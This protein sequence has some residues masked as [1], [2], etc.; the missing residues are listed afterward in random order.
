LKNEL[1]LEGENNKLLELIIKE[2]SRLNTILTE[3]LQYAKLGET[4]LGKVDLGRIV[5]EVIE[6]AKKHPSYQARIDLR[7][8]LGDF[9]LYILAEENQLKQLLLNLLVNALEAMEEKG[10]ELIITCMPSDLEIVRNYR[11]EKLNEDLFLPLAIIDQGKGIPEE[12]MSKIFLPFYSTKKNGTG[13]GLAIVQR[14]VT[15]L[16]GRIE[17]K[18][19]LGQ[20]TAFIVYL[21][22][23]HGVK[24]EVAR[25]S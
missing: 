24:K 18:S 9:P 7:K 21:H 11:K 12:Q 14:I 4:P 1:N 20:G 19:K 8:R 17:C 10:N 15:N 6:I 2:S 22:R 13:L 3:F 5:D 25:V 16:N 23:Y